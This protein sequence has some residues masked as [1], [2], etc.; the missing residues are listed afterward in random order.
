MTNPF[1]HLLAMELPE[2]PS[3][4]ELRYVRTLELT[5]LAYFGALTHAAEAITNMAKVLT[6]KNLLTSKEV[7]FVKDLIPESA[8][9]TQ[10]RLAEWVQRHS[11]KRS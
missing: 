10:H 11:G 7:E 5:H 6:S 4:E 8:S 9:A 1:E 2:E 3:A